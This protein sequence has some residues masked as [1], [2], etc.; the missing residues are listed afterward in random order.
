MK[1]LLVLCILV[2]GIVFWAYSSYAF[3][4]GFGSAIGAEQV[5][6]KGQE[7][8]VIPKTPGAGGQN[9]PNAPSTPFG[10]DSG[11]T[12]TTYTYSTSATDPDSDQVKY[13]WDY[14]G[15]GTVDEWSSLGASGW[16]DTRTH[17][18]S[19]PNTYTIKVRAQDSNGAQSGWSGAKTVTI[20]GWNKSDVGSSDGTGGMM[21]VAIGNG[22]ND[23]AMRVYGGN[24]NC[25]IYEFTYSGGVWNRIYVGPGGIVGIAI[26]NGRNDGVM[27]VYGANSSNHIY[28]FTWE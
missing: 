23:G 9:V 28:E 11:T 20:K 14:D 10:P 17:S 4:V 27:R 1:K 21:C 12:N 3:F 15:N 18:W 8:G 13:G 5:I 19:T 16:T 24:V 6:K 22:R 2:I 7:Q 26:G 25:Y